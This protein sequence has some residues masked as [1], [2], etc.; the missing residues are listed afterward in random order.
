V[1]SPPRQCSSALGIVLVSSA[2]G[3]PS[4][5]SLSA[6]T[7]LALCVDSMRWLMHVDVVW[8][9]SAGGTGPVERVSLPFV[10]FG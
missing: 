9:H 1:S 5:S 3:C 2:T 6:P 10:R 8:T 7:P 4:L